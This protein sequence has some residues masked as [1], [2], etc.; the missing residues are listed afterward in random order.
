M[1]KLFLPPVFGRGSALLLL[2]GGPLLP[3]TV[4]KSLG[5]FCHLISCVFLVS[6]L[7]LPPVFGR[8]SAL[9]LLQGGP[10]LPLTVE[11]SLGYFVILSALSAQPLVCRKRCEWLQLG[12]RKKKKEENC[13]CMQ[14]K[15]RVLQLEKSSVRDGHFGGCR[16]VRATNPRTGEG[17]PT[18]E[19]AKGDQPKNWQRATNPRTGKGRPTQELAT[20]DQPKNW[21][22]ATNPRT[23]EGR[24]TQELASLYATLCVSCLPSQTGG[25]SNEKNFCEDRSSETACVGS[26]SFE[27]YAIGLRLGLE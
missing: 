3:L 20:G 13:M 1:Y 27:K 6:L 21:R 18:Q 2:Q 8:G 16:K 4:E 12:L 24:P 23:G 19:L 7:P 25:C 11:K 15:L 9:L 10:L 5:Y 17:R 26:M 22:R 14:K